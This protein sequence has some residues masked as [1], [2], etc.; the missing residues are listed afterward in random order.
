MGLEVLGLLV[1]RDVLEEGGLV[2]E[3]LVAAVALVGLVGL[4]AARVGLEVTELTE[5][6]KNRKKKIENR[7]T[8]I[9][10]KRGFTLVQPGCLH[11]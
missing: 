1:L 11:L 2:D 3:T 6:L 4:V 7:S 9:K 10:T 5:R 8:N